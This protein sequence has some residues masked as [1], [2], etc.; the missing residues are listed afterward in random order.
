MPHT[1][2]C[3][4]SAKCRAPTH[5]LSIECQEFLHDLKEFQQSARLTEEVI[6]EWSENLQAAASAADPGT[7][8]ES[9]S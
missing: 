4:E 5:E 2:D 7:L 8:D 3:A 9:T 1:P 6:A